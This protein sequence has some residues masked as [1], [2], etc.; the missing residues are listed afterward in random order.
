[1]FPLPNRDFPAQRV[2]TRSSEL[3]LF[4]FV[5]RLPS[6]SKRMSKRLQTLKKTLMFYNWSIRSPLGS[7]G[8]ALQQIPQP[9]LTRWRE[10]QEKPEEDMV[11]DGL[12]IHSMDQNKT[13]V[14]TTIPQWCVDGEK[15]KGKGQMKMSAAIAFFDEISSYC[16][17]VGWDKQGR[18]GLSL[19]LSGRRIKGWGEGVSVG[20]RIWVETTKRRVGRTVGFLDIAVFDSQGREIIQGQHMKFMPVP[21]GKMM[22]WLAGKIVGGK[23]IGVGLINWWAEKRYPIHKLKQ[24]QSIE[25]VFELSDDKV[26]TTTPTVYPTPTTPITTTT[27]QTPPTTTTTSTTPISLPN[28][29]MTSN[30]I[31]KPLHANS[32]GAL[33]GG[34][35]VMLST[36]HATKALVKCLGR[37][38]LTPHYIKT[39]LISGVKAKNKK[40]EVE[41]EVIAEELSTTASPLY[42]T[43]TLITYNS[44]VCYDSFIQWGPEEKESK[45]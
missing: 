24:F 20:D 9:L 39:T 1:M 19:Q 44:R 28:N 12:I 3:S 22:T 4:F 30:I 33:H 35:S 42:Q 38:D 29:K 10:E 11:G 32:L 16:G 36:Q 15:G 37:E 8:T 45:E 6:P 2:A 31:I 17:A 40:V 14:S 26:T 27:T 5:G 21:L 18:P 25:E 34:A 41:T 7:F 43:R 13:V 23:G